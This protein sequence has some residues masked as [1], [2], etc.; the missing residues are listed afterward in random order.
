MMLLC[1]LA[2]F[3]SFVG[4]WLWI[5]LAG[6]R[7]L[8]DIPVARS[9][10]SQ[11]TVRGGGMVFVSIFLIFIWAEQNISQTVVFTELGYFSI[12]IIMLVGFIDDLRGVSALSR[13][14]VQLV[15]ATLLILPASTAETGAGFFVAGSILAAVW[16]INLYNFMDG[17]DGIA[18]IQAIS[19]SLV[20]AI[21][22]FWHGQIQLAWLLVG[23]AACVSGFL[24]WNFPVCRIFMG[25]S[26]SAAL[27]TIFVIFVIKSSQLSAE[28]FW[29]WLILMAVFIVDTSWTLLVRLMTGQKIWTAHN[30]HAY[31]KLSRRWQSHKKVSFLVAGYNLC[32]L[33]PMLLAVEMGLLN[34]HIA[35][36]FAWGPMI[37]VC[38]WLRAG[39]LIP[40]NEAN[41]R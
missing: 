14:F 13:L 37:V 2:L 19:V 27:G 21:V 40:C 15:T 36:I 26:G 29:Y 34:K 8:Q 16:L 7:F 41:S 35:L 18:S 10:H 17:I 23:L 22:L 3:T 20:M 39:Q 31:Q 38:V 4:T 6:Q 33:A 1:L 28:F 9:S 5:R 32:W 25:D 11:P 24:Y 12:L 30:L